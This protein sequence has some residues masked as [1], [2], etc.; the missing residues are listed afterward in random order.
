MIRSLI[1]FKNPK[2]KASESFR[3]LRTN[4]QF[5]SVGKNLKMILGTSSAPSDGK[6]TI[7]SNLAITYAQ[8]G[9][10]TLLID[11]DLRKPTMHKYFVISN[12]T[13]I[14][15]YIINDDDIKNY[16]Q[17]TSVPNLEVVASGPIPPNPSELLCSDKVKLLFQSLKSTYD[18]ILLDAPPVIAVTD[19]QILATLA[20]GVILVAPHSGVEKRALAKAKE[21]LDNVG[22]NVLGVVLNKVP[23]H[24]EIRYYG[25]GYYYGQ[26]N[27]YYTK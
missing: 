21:L 4:I 5:S 3:T 26:Y 24:S 6:S 12:N 14:S 10:K 11:C 9:Y 27:S 2:S 23:E 13:G 22:A 7:I 19:A 15:N 1:T 8:A 18:I 20:D 25:K 16:I 17:A